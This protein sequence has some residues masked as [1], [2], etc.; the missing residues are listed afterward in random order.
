MV[1]STRQPDV[2]SDLEQMPH[3]LNFIRGNGTMM[4]NNHAVPITHTANAILTSLA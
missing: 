1:P 3:L 4:T 2:P